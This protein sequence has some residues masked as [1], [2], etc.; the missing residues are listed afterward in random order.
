[1]GFAKIFNRLGD[2]EQKEI[3]AWRSQGQGQKSHRHNSFTR[4]TFV[5]RYI[6]PPNINQKSSD[7]ERNGISVSRSQGQGPRSQ[8]QGQRSHCFF[9]ATHPLSPDTS[10]HQIS[11]HLS[12]KNLHLFRRYRAE[13]NY[14]AILGQGQR[15]HEHKSFARHTFVPWYI[16]TPKINQKSWFV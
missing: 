16:L 6:L 15:S 8:S 5:P 3:L 9:R 14:T 1:M 12:S 4:H 11:T 10:S 2:T 13:G 7:T